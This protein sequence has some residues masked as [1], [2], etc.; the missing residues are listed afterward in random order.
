MVV[1]SGVPS[2]SEIIDMVKFGTQKDRP[3][4]KNGGQNCR[5]YFVTLKKG[6]FR[7]SS[8]N[9]VTD[10]D[11]VVLCDTVWKQ[12]LMKLCNCMWSSLIMYLT[13]I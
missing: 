12:F 11:E 10:I 2:P 6:K 3:D 1:S 9:V 7:I 4:A 5:T 13:I 8:N